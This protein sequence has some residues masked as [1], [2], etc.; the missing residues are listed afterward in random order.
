MIGIVS[1]RQGHV[2][3]LENY[4]FPRDFSTDGADRRLCYKPLAGVVNPEFRW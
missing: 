3:L 2:G 1:I 4:L